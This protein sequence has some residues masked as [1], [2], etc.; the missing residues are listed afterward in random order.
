MNAAAKICGGGQHGTA[1]RE[2]RQSKITQRHLRQKQGAAKHEL[3][4]VQQ[5]HGHRITKHRCNVLPGGSLQ[6]IRLQYR[7]QRN[8]AAGDNLKVLVKF[9]HR[10]TGDLIA[11]GVG[12]L[13]EQIGF[14]I[15]AEAE[16]QAALGFC[17]TRPQTGGMVR[18]SH[19]GAV[20][21]GC[22]MSDAVIHHVEG[23]SAGAPSLLLMVE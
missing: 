10:E 11:K 12:M 15:K 22:A 20:N 3:A 16:F 7:D 4:G 8:K 5:I 6:R 9:L 14:R 23:V 18:N 19:L 21:I 13:G 1:L 2:A 17:V